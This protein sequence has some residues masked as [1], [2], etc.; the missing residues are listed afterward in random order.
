ME[1]PEVKH[2]RLFLISF[3]GLIVNLIGR[4]VFQHGGNGECS[5]AHSHGSS[6]GVSHGHSHDHSHDHHHGHSNMMNGHTHGDHHHD[7]HHELVGGSQSQIMHGVF[8]H[9]LAD[10][11]GSVGVI[12][13]ALL[14]GQFGWMIADP[15]CSMFIAC[16]VALSVIPLLRNSFGILMQRTPV[17]LEKQL[18]GCYQRVCKFLTIFKI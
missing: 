5:H 2:E 10:T 13:S 17:E 4:F 3:L 1:P 16:L 11:L 14:M 15:I 7:H 6:H 9:I 8:L 18:P 12:I